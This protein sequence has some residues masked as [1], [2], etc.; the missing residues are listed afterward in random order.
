MKRAIFAVPSAV[1]VQFGS[2]ALKFTEPGKLRWFAQPGA[3]REDRFKAYRDPELHFVVMTHQALRDDI[4]HAVAQHQ[5]V[6]SEAA[7]RLILRAPEDQRN[8]AI[9]DAT[10]AMGWKFDMAVYDEAHDALNR[11]G[12]PN[13]ILA[14]S[15]DSFSHPNNIEYYMGMTASPVKNDPSE[16]YDWLRKVAPQKYGSPQ[17]KERFMH[18]Y[19]VDT[20]AAKASMQREVMP[21]F[22]A[23]RIPSGTNAEYHTRHAD[24]LE[25]ALTMTSH[26]RDAYQGVM[27]AYGKARLARR[28]RELDVASIKTLSP[29]SFAGKPKSEH[30]DIAR[31]LSQSLGVMRD[32]ALRRVVNN[33][34]IAT[35]IKT[36]ELTKIVEKHK[37]EPGIIFA[38]YR[39]SVKQIADDLKK[40]GYRVGV[41]TG[42]N[43]A[44]EK[45]NIRLGFH[46]PGGV[47]PK[48]D[49]LVMSDAGAIGQNLQRG[50]WLVHWDTPMTQK[51]YEQRTGRIDRLGQ[52]HDVNVYDLYTDTGLE[53]EDRRRLLH[54][55]E[56]GEIFQSPTH[57]IDDSGMAAEIALAERRNGQER[58]AKAA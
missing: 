22:Y 36:P 54:K 25:S 31:N 14:N 43:N 41:M 18:R 42:A 33:H 15:L 17:A 35:N 34:M 37:G 51:T 49:I 52:T 30:E 13:S 8:K 57:L 47:N 32:G 45:A 56:L 58:A 4:V 16:A 2:E 28:H 50:R 23:D 29:S 38:H 11:R 12:K 1:Q 55:R 53:R 44:E 21:Y 40:R 46:P 19:G 6:S 26:Q 5:G 20:P 7:T 3:S 9:R 39:N 10:R 48:Y 27:E 24:G